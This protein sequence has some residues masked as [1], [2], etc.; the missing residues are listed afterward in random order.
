M[1]KGLIF[2]V[3]AVGAL[4]L[5]FR[6]DTAPTTAA[7]ANDAASTAVRTAIAPPVAAPREPLPIDAFKLAKFDWAKGGFDTVAVVTVTF[8]NDNRYDVKDAVLECDFHGASGT[9][10]AR[11]TQTVY[12]RFPAGKAK[13][14]R[15][16]NMGFVP[17]QAAKAGCEVKAVVRA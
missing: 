3:F 11:L 12:Q 5:F 15:E 7:T 4:A 14:V 16:I 9:R 2:I 13:T 8:K 17:S 10:I 6:P 1:L